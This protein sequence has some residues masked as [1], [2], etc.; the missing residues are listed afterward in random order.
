L[1]SYGLDYT[2]IGIFGLL[3]LPYAL[4]PL[5]APLLDHVPLPLLTRALGQ[6][7]SWLCLV[8]ITAIIGLL[9]MVSQNPVENL[10]AFVAFGFLVTIS[11]AS[12]HVLMLTYQIETLSSRD[13]G[14]GEG[15]SVFAYRMAILTAGPGALSLATLLSWQ[16]IYIIISFLMFIGLMAVLMVGEP[17]GFV[18][19]RTPSFSK[20]GE[21]LRYAFINPFKEFMTQK[22]WVA[23]LVFMLIYRL[24]E[25]FLSMMQTLFLLD[26]GFTYIE[27]S[28]VAKTFGMAASLFGGF[29]G[30]YWIR[31]Y[32]Y[33][34]TLVWGALAHGVSCLLFLI[35]EKL[36]ANIP[37]LYVTVGIEHFF[38]GVMLTGFLSYQLTCANMAFAA[39]QLALLTSF[40]NLTSVFA[41]PLAGVVIDH[42]GWVPF[43][44]LVVLSSIP[45]ILWVYRIPF[46]RI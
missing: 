14:V 22:G 43:L 38:S 35:Q 5:W 28:A 20:K 18:E 33:K 34:K 23:I 45:G 37:F 1:K 24:P 2:S 41:K 6:R 31:L 42:F 8:Q 17:E 7:R 44:V 11:A 12:Q 26:L 27:I 21:W 10:Y 39:T 40:A 3:H 36:G 19:H 30:G 29:I 15:M 32:G 4:K 13:W 46:P 9:G 16:E 25:N